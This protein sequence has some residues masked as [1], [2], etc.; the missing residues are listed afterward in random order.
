[1]VLLLPGRLLSAGLLELLRTMNLRRE[2][3]RGYPDPE[4]GPARQD[5]QRL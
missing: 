5:I 3:Q 1:M 2:V 4:Q